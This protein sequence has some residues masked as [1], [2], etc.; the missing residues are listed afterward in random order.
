MLKINLDNKQERQWRE[1]VAAMT[2][3]YPSF[4]HLLYS[5]MDSV[6]SGNNAVFT[7][8]ISVAATDG[9]SLILNPNAFFS[10]EF[11]LSN[12]I[13]VTAHEILHVVLEHIMLGYKMHTTGKVPFKDGSS[14]KYDQN[15]MNQAMDYIVNAILTE[16]KVGEMPTGKYKGLYDPKIATANSDFLDVYRKLYNDDQNGGGGSGGGGDDHGGEICQHKEPGAASGK[17]P[18][19]TV[20]EHNPQK[21]QQAVAAAMQAAKV[22]GKLP[23]ALERLF[24]DVL[25]PK[26]EWRDHIRS[27]LARKAGGGGYD[28]HK[29]DDE[30]MNREIYVPSRSGYGA[31]SIVVGVDTSGSIGPKEVDMFLA[32]V[33]G[34]LED[35]RP[36]RLFLVWCDAKVHRADECESESDLR[37]IRA[38]GAPGGGGTDF[39]PVFDWIHEQGIT[40]DALV[41]LTDLLGTFPNQKPSYPVIWGNIYPDGKAPWGDVVDVPKQAA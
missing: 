13:F 28:F 25:E 17:D 14:A 27:L 24:G 36:R 32:E 34:I 26:V 6:G 22:M 18:T 35:L 38:K 39:R 41:Y 3:H 16:S 2:W 30:W 5:L 10:D 29:P 19:S 37:V 12:R 4:T 33:S 11:K 7:D 9:K 15:I 20:S 21:V 40:P 23:A 1:T 8:E 31:G